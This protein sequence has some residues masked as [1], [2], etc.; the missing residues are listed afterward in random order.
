VDDN[1]LQAMRVAVTPHLGYLKE[2]GIIK[3]FGFD[4]ARD[5]VLVEWTDAYARLLRAGR[6]I[7]SEPAF[8]RVCAVA[9]PEAVKAWIEREAFTIPP[10]RGRSR[11]R[12]GQP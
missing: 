11:K 9:E 5:A 4:V 3:D 8:A 2:I 1:D 7:E 6:W 10:A 12:R